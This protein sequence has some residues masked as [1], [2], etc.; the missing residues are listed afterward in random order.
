MQNRMLYSTEIAGEND[1]LPFVLQLIIGNG[2]KGEIVPLGKLCK[3]LDK[4][5]ECIYDVQELKPLRL[6]LQSEQDE[7]V[8]FVWNKVYEG[9]KTDV[10][11]KYELNTKKRIVLLYEHGKTDYIYPWRC[12]LYHFE[13]QIAEQC[14]YGAFRI[15]P[16]NFYDDQLAL[17]QQKVQSI[18]ASLLIDRG[19][20]KKTFS[21]FADLDDY[22]YIHTI[23]WMIKKIVLIK[24]L[25]ARLE[26]EGQYKS[27]YRLE[28]RCR[29]YTDWSAK[30][31][32]IYEAR[33]QEKHWNRR[34]IETHNNWANQYIKYKTK[35]LVQLVNTLMLFLR[36]N[37]EKLEQM[38]ESSYREKQAVQ[39]I[40]QT[41]EKNGSVTERDKQKYRNIQ[42]LKDTDVK[43]I[44]VKKQEYK[45]LYEIMKEWLFWLSALLRSPFWSNI[46]ENANVRPAEIRP[47]HRQLLSVLEASDKKGNYAA[48]ESMFLFVYKPTFMIYEYYVYFELISILENLGFS[49]PTPI[50]EQVQKYFY[51]DGLHD[52]TTI[53]LE[54]DDICLHVVFNELIETHPIIAL[55]KGS[56]FYNGEDTKKP[57]IRIDYYR[58][59]EKGYAYQSSIIVEVKYSPMYNIF[60]PI[61]NTKATEQMY[62]YWSIKYVS[63]QEGK[64]VFQRRAIYEVVCVYPGSQVHAKK[65]EAGCGMFLQF[66]PYKTK[67]GVEKL[68][69]QNQFVQLFQ[70]WLGW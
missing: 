41:I 6:Q 53:V 37:L 68:A 56:H 25:Y 26:K 35:R 45:V 69:G 5:S 3:S 57:D 30:K 44:T 36:E 24:Q 51:L 27:I 49:A 62:K 13:V 47:I 20:Y 22:S 65:I 33:G 1:K 2:G 21:L 16:K 59:I 15:T 19:H 9:K 7:H 4:I 63:E 38:A 48:L 66:Y 18:F 40:L 32:D 54:K 29:K 50:R 64:R 43:K 46:S 39:E 23:R 34:V 8:I 60:Q 11:W 70:E 17:I 58:K 28:Q 67:Q 61:G 52:G 55:S 42:L 12:G 31:N 10:E 14:Y